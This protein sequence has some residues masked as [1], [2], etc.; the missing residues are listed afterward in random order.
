[1]K[2]RKGALLTCGLLFTIGAFMFFVCRVISSVEL[3]LAGRLIVGFASG[4]ATSTVPMY[5]AEL[6]P[7]ELRGTL[8]VL[9]SMGKIVKDL[10]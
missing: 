6:A 9:T 1:M 8:A 2:I 10:F 7:L 3:L 5:L 4:L